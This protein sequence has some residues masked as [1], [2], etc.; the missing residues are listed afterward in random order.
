MFFWWLEWLTDDTL[1]VSNVVPMSYWMSY[2]SYSI[3]SY[4]ILSCEMLTFY[5]SRKS[6]KYLFDKEKTRYGV[7]FTKLE[8]L[9]WPS[10]G[11]GPSI[12]ISFLTD[13]EQL[14]GTL[15]LSHVWDVFLQHLHHE[16]WSMT[17][18]DISHDSWLIYRW[19]SSCRKCGECYV[20]TPLLHRVDQIQ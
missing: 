18:R 7:I 11:F 4:E 14:K 12:F 6:R 3:P 5:R 20:G 9:I 17:H 19:F 15:T 13:F 10:P 8:I 2:W 16:S 1:S